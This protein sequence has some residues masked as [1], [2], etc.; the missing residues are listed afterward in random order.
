MVEPDT[1]IDGRYRVI[2]RLGSGGM[3][4]VYLAEDQLLGRSLAVKVLHHHFAED[5]EFVERFRREASSAAGLSHPNI[6]G[7]FD[8]G[9]WD[10]TYYIAMEYVPGRSLKEL[11]RDQG[12]L[13]PAMA[14]D[15]VTQILQAA[16]FAHTRGVIHRDLKPH[17]VIL[18]EEGRA[19]V[20]DFGI[21][22]AG[23]SDMTMTGSIMGTAQYLSPEQAQGHAV[24]AASDLY[25]VGVILYELLTGA[26]PFD[27]DSAVA[28]AFK[29]VSAQPLAPSVANP[30]TPAVL[31][32]IVLRAL[33]KDPAARY[34]NAEEFIAALRGARERLPAGTATAIFATPPPGVRAP[35]TATH[36]VPVGAALST[37]VPPAAL[38]LPPDGGSLGA[39]PPED[40]DQQAAKKRR[41]MWLALAGAAIAAIVAIV[42]VLAL[43]RPSSGGH[44]T[45]PS[46]VGQSEAAAGAVMRRAG[47]VPVPALTSSSTVADGVVISETPPAGSIVGKGTRVT[48][49]V[50]TG[51]GSS[52]LPNVA[53]LTASQA[54]AKLKEAGF[55][56]TT[57]KQPSATVA[58]GRVISTNPSAGTETQAG[59]SVTVLVSSGP[60]QTTVPDVVGQSRAAAEATLTN[61]KLAP[62]AIT[63]RTSTEQSPGTVL[64]QSPATGSSL[65]DGGT[66]D[67]TVAQAPTETPVPNV[68][69][70]NEAQASAELGRAG[71]TPQ[72]VTQTTTEAAKV[73]IVLRQSPAAPH[74]ARKG[75]TVTI[76]VGVLGSQTTPTTTTPSTPVTPT[77]PAASG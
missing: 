24:S 29:Q 71:F 17:N 69:G 4:D 5:Q 11:V 47:L 48:I 27:G 68:V 26:V 52:P 74:K 76:A 72:A 10:G 6:V 51:P 13:E 58:S 45:V 55:E 70:K 62:G 21:A 12:P 42:L 50:S 40:E 33:A 56:P 63:Q 60:A 66:V 19:R 2:S 20:T 41:V 18:D 14:I 8:R 59:S 54:S 3:A 15:I 64:E 25:A 67:L 9:E 23:A 39:P 7:I 43:T 46:V 1:I 73:G 31:D 57:E 35:G 16:R 36:T 75:A 38:M 65:P 49:A 30:A 34:A 22:Q 28:I 44:V 53:G 77:P 32:E 37:G 61:A